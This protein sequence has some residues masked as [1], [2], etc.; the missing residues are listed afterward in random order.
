MEDAVRRAHDRGI[1]V[2]SMKPLGG[3]NLFRKAED[4]LRYVLALPYVDSVAIGMQST[5]E[6]DA[7]LHFWENGAFTPEQTIALGEKKRHLH[8]DDWCEGCGKC[9]ETCGQKALRIEDGKAVCNH[10]RCVLC[11]YCSAGCPAWAIKVV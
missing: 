10:E 5:D 3:G 8:V 6:V 9:A 11:G 7:N 4:C 1:G 2:Y